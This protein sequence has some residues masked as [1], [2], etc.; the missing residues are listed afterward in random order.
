MSS[1]MVA[2]V[3]L[4]WGF[5]LC[6]HLCLLRCSVLQLHLCRLDLGIGVWIVFVLILRKNYGVFTLSTLG[7]FVDCCGVPA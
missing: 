5:C 2:V 3:L 6:V 4:P 1:L 7:R